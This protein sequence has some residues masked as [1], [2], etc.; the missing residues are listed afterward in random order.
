MRHALVL[1][2]LIALAA[3]IVAGGAQGQGSKIR[4]AVV[5]PDFRT[6]TAMLNIKRA[7]E[8]SAKQRGNVE[9]TVVG[10][11]TADGQ[12]KAMENAIAADVDA[13]IY[14]SISG[15]A[16]TK[17][18][19][20][21][22]AANIPVV[23][24]VSC[25]PAGTH[26]SKMDFD[27]KGIGR[28]MG[29]WALRALKAGKKKNGGTPVLAI[30]DTD[31]SDPAFIQIYAGFFEPLKA[32]GIK[33]KKVQSPPTHYDPAKGLTYVNALLTANPRIDALSCNNDTLA[34]ACYQA[35][36]AAGRTDI[37]FSGLNGDCANLKLILQ[38]EQDFTV[39]LGFIGGSPLAL[40]LAVNA[41][42]GKPVK[43]ATKVPLQGVTTAQAK[44]ILA[45]KLKSAVP[46]AR[47]LLRQAKAGC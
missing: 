39:I 14:N 33:Y 34:L 24:Y 1:V 8:A 37:P 13:I 26:A 27:L 41:A 23:C 15:N 47:E 12:V 6:N 18:V 16:F 43:K 30:L 45:G 11:G 19:K 44:A 20:K 38:G 17:A 42:Q 10:S 7:L 9:L 29:Q 32:S 22:N 25:A 40:D 36:K 28:P 2:A 3:G 35:L 4:V 5:L 46:N 21:A 31:K